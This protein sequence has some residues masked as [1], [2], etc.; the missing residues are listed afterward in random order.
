MQHDST[1]R[2]PRHTFSTFACPSTTERSVSRPSTDPPARPTEQARAGLPGR[3]AVFGAASFLPCVFGFRLRSMSLEAFDLARKASARESLETKRSTLCSQNRNRHGS[4]L[5]G[6]W[7]RLRACLLCACDRRRLRAVAGSWSARG[8]DPNRRPRRSSSSSRRPYISS[9][10]LSDHAPCQRP[11]DRCPRRAL[12]PSAAL[13]SCLRRSSRSVPSPSPRSPLLAAFPSSTALYHIK[14]LPRRIGAPSARHGVGL[15]PVHRALS[16][17]PA[18]QLHPLHGRRLD[19]RLDPR[20]E[21][22]WALGW[23]E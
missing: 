23:L 7:V 19:N 4:K 9:S 14:E 15:V 18:S 1:E 21:Q 5:Q 20:L 16:P 12:Q 2:R 17:V 6:Y 22:R 3:T 11:A 13:D 10:A 8:C